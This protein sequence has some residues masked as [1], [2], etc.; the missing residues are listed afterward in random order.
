MSPL[1]TEQRGF[2]YYSLTF[3]FSQR[4]ISFIFFRRS[5]CSALQTRG[6][7]FL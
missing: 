7:P 4:R 2:G 3:R 6:V 1:S 5:R